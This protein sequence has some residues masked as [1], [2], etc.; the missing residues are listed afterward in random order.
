MLFIINR[1]WSTHFFSVFLILYSPISL[2]YRVQVVAV[3]FQES[4]VYPIRKVNLDVCIKVKHTHKYTLTSLDLLLF[5]L[6]VSHK[7]TKPHSSLTWDLKMH[8]IWRQY[9]SKRL[10]L[11]VC[12][13]LCFDKFHICLSVS[14]D[15]GGMWAF[16]HFVGIYMSCCNVFTVKKIWHTTECKAFALCMDVCCL[17]QKDTGCQLKDTMP[18]L[19]SNLLYRHHYYKL[20][21]DLHLLRH[22]NK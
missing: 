17:A 6:S 8:L 16:H 12:T 1:I 15:S 9:P 18:P 21:L 2:W 4:S 5:F 11:W 14:G 22:K 20:N 10:C 19:H 13:S 7:H 3:F